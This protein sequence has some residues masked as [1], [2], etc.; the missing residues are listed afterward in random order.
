[1]LAVRGAEA[2][3]CRVV[4]R[5]LQG[6]VVWPLGSFLASSC[7]RLK[8]KDSGGSKGEEERFLPEG[9]G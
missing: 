4:E 6:G 3:S 1:M 2:A 5:Q 7:R 8:G 9:R